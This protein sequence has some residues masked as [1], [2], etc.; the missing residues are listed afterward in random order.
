VFRVETL[1]FAFLKLLM[2]FGRAGAAGCFF[3]GALTQPDFG[4]RLPLLEKQFS[5]IEACFAPDDFLILKASSPLRLE[6][7]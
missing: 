1:F 6:K 4:V 3:G 5:G 2:R 7:G